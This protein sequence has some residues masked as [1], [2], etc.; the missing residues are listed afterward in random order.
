MI[1]RCKIYFVFFIFV[2][3]ANHE[4]IFTT[5]FSRSTVQTHKEHSLR[6]LPAPLDFDF[7]NCSDACIFGVDFSAKGRGPSLKFSVPAR[8]W[9]SSASISAFDPVLKK[10]LGHD[11]QALLCFTALSL[12]IPAMQPSHFCIPNLTVQAPPT[13]IRN[14]GGSRILLSFRT[15]AL[16]SSG[17]C[18]KAKCSTCK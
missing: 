3:C 10:G 6:S 16:C 11:Y 8:N 4:N 15:V 14:R 7:S 17:Q 1:I 9:S 5:K 13:V 18:T 12:L 2:V